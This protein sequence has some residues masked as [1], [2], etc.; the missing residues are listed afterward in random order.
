MFM[1][2]TR[3]AAIG[4][5]AAM[6]AIAALGG[7]PRLDASLPSTPGDADGDLV[8][9]DLEWATLGDPARRDTDGDGLDDFTALVT[10]QYPSPLDPQGSPG[11]GSYA[12]PTPTLPNEHTMRVLASLRQDANGASAV[13]VHLAFRFVGATIPPIQALDVWL[14]YGQL[15]WTLRDLLGKTGAEFQI[16]VRQDGVYLL[17]SSR[18]ALE[19]D[20]VAFTPSTIGAT[21]ALDGRLLTSGVLLTAH[22]GKLAAFT[23]IGADTGVLVPLDTAVVDDPFWSSDRVCFMSLSVIA[24]TGNGSLCE[25]T[26]AQCRRSENLR[27]PPTCLSAAGQVLFVPDGIATLTGN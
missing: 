18:I 1:R 26:R 2:R 25:V 17:F 10:Y 15:S 14:N 5:I 4:W 9:D 27:C 20:F 19:Q 8:P 6:V 21:I 24:S 11:E 3:P 12:P 23:P 16:E 7:A 22:A 13:W